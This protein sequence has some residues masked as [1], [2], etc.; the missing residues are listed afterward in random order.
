M[1]QESF[2]FYLAEACSQLGVD[3]ADIGEHGA[4]AVGDVQVNVDYAEPADMCRIVVDLGPMPRERAAD[5]FRLMLEAN[6]LD[7]PDILPVFSLHPAAA[8]AIL[9]LFVPVAGL[10]SRRN[11]LAVLLSERVP[12]LI[13]GWADMA[14]NGPPEPPADGETATASHLLE[15]VALVSRHA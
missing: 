4:L 12:D 14:Q 13:D 2:Q 8:R 10:D 5:L 3:V 6:C 1:S 7:A 11:D 15:S 9:T